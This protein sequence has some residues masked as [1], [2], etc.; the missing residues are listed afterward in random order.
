MWLLLICALSFI[1][2]LISFR[3]RFAKRVWINISTPLL[4]TIIVVII[5]ALLIRDNYE[6][7]WRL[8]GVI[9]AVG[10]GIIAAFLSEIPIAIFLKRKDGEGN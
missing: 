6:R 3:V 8:I 2:G 5:P 9:P 10:C 1:V 4:L 7:F